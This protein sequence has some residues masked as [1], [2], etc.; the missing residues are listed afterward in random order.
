MKRAT[1]RNHTAIRCVN[2][3]RSGGD[4]RPGESRLQAELGQGESL[5]GAEP[6]QG[7]LTHAMQD[8][9]IVIITMHKVSTVH[10]AAMA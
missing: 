2:R 9:A 8:T 4:S 10:M 5:P 3:I 1:G 7:D 6:D